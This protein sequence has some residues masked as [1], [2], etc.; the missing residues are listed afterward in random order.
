MR[1]YM[2]VC[3]KACTSPVASMVWVKDFLTG[4]TTVRAAWL[5][6]AS[7][8]ELPGRSPQPDTTSAVTLKAHKTVPLEV[9]TLA[10]DFLGEEGN[11][12]FA[13]LRDRV[14]AIALLPSVAESRTSWAGLGAWSTSP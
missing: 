10:P 9:M 5:F 1:E 6:F 2:G 3:S 11:T 13:D 4:L 8:S 12:R 14:K 7:R